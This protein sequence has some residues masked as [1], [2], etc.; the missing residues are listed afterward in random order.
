MTWDAVRVHD[1]QSKKWTSQLSELQSTLILA[2]YKLG[3]TT[4]FFKPLCK[5][6]VTTST[7]EV[8]PLGANLVLSDS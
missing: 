8:T 7:V 3:A 5:Q 4:T 6:L 2:N 1:A